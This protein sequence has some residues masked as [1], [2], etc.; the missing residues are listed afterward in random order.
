MKLKNYVRNIQII[1]QI[2]NQRTNQIIDIRYFLK[3][4]NNNKAED[5]FKELKNWY[6]GYKL[7]DDTNEK[8]YEIYTPFSIVNALK[9]NKIENFWSMSETYL[10]LYN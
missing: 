6:D 3:N 1:K 2:L 9:Q 7:K 8:V 4:E 10:L 5:K